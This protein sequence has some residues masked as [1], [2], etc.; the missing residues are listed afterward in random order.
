MPA[1]AMTSTNRYDVNVSGNV[2]PIYSWKFRRLDPLELSA[3]L[4]NLA[5]AHLLADRFS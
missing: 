3:H 4:L 5:F 2:K 1:R